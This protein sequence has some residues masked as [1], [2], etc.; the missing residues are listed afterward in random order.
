RDPQ[1]DLPRERAWSQ[2]AGRA[3]PSAQIG[4]NDSPQSRKDG[5]PFDFVFQLANIPRPQLASQRI[6]GALGDSGEMLAE[7]S[8][9]PCEECLRKK[10]DVP[11]AA[12]KRLQLQLESRQ[13]VVQ[14]FAKPA[15]FN[16]FQ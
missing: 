14:V 10:S 8:A 9:R 12:A 3:E 5:G 2:R 6:D 4:A 7:P 1:R 11:T 15:S 16:F 13:A